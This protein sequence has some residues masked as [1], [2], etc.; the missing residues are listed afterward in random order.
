MYASIFDGMRIYHLL[1]FSLDRSF[2][3]VY[4][5]RRTYNGASNNLEILYMGRALE[6]LR[7]L[8][9][10]AYQDDI[11]MP[12]GACSKQ[13][14]ESKTCPYPDELSGFGSNR[15]SPRLISNELF[16]QVCK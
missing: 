6:N 15:P 1:L 12:A 8:V 10:S 2:I 5:S 7:R 14:R 4:L 11:S 13:Q 3:S 9:P 16:A